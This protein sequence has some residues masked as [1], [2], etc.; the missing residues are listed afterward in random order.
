[1]RDI[2]FHKIFEAEDQLHPDSIALIDKEG[3]MS[4]TSREL[5][6]KSDILASHMQLL[7]VH[8][9]TY[10]GLLVDNTFAITVSILGI[11]KSGG[12]YVQMDHGLP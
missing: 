7:G 6:R 5:D 3:S 2:C 10:L 4:M 12:D 11:L 1:M 8:T 9:N